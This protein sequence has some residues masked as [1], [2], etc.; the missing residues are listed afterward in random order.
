[1]DVIPFPSNYLSFGKYEAIDYLPYNYEKASIALKEFLGL[2][3][4]KYFY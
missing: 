2:F 4:Y 3:F 1:M